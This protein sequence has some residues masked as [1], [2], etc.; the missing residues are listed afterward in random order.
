MPPLF[1]LVPTAEFERDLA[2]L[3][4]DERAEVLRRARAIRMDPS[5]DG[6][7]RTTVPSGDRR[8]VAYT[9]SDLWIA[10]RHIDNAT[11]GL[12]A[13]GRHPRGPQYRL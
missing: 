11:I 9:G 7:T 6:I 4:P 5:I 8:Y 2:E 13:C 10:Y 3:T 1:E 12:L